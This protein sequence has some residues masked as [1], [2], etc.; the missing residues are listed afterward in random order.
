MIDPTR[1]RIAPLVIIIIVALMLFACGV[2]IYASRSHLSALPS[3]PALATPTPVR[4]GSPDPASANAQATIDAGQSQ[5]A[6]LSL[7]ATQASLNVSQAADAAAQSTQDANQLQQAQLDQQATAIGLEIA[8]AAA[9]QDAIQQQTKTAKEAIADARS[10]AA[11]ATQS[12]NRINRALI[13][14]AQVIVDGQVTQTAQAAAALTAYPLTA[15]PLAATQAALLLTQYDR[16]QK[17]FVDRIVVPA[18]PIVA[19]ILLLLLFILV[20]SLAYRRVLPAVWP[21]RL[22]IG[23]AN[24]NP[25]VMIDGVIAE[26]T[27]PLHQIIPSEPTPAALPLLP[28]EKIVHVEIVTATEAP[29]AHWI[30]EVE[31]QLA[32]AGGL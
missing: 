20:I 13:A 11:A 1:P 8:H 18:I 30:A 22:R 31:Q 14:Q 5:L 3:A 17:A 24:A 7:K 19:L 10:T 16:E 9:T 4:I 29:V 26:H 32:N 12:A 15:T 27:L 6:D 25:L 21:R 2:G 23:R 28:C